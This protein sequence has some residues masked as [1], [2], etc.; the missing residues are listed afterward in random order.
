MDK[1]ACI[2]A[3]GVWG[4]KRSLLKSRDR[5]YTPAVTLVREIL[6]GC[7]VAYMRDDVTGWCEGMNEHG[8]GITNAALAVG[9][10]E[11]EGKLVKVT[12]KTTR[13]GKRIL[14]A[15]ACDNIDDAVESVCE[16]MNGLKG[17]T[18]L[19]T[20]D[21]V[22]CVEQ[23]REHEC[24]VKELN[25]DDLH[26]RTNHGHYHTDA[27]YTEGEDYVS[28]VIRREKALLTLRDLDTPYDLGPGLMKGRMEDRKDPNNMVRD[29]NNMSTTSQMVMNLSD[30]EVC[31]YVLP[32]KMDYEGL[33]DN[34]PEGYE[35]KI[36]LKVYGYRAG[37]KELVELS[38]KTGLR[39]KSVDP[40]KL[41]SRYLR[42][43]VPEKYK[44]IDFKPP[45]SVA[46]AAEKGL[47][48]RQK[49]SPSNRGGLTPS[50]AAEQGIG[51]G[52]QRAVNLKNRDNISPEVI[53]QMVGFFSRHEKNKGVSPEHKGEPWNDK[54]NVAWLIWGGDPGRAWAEK[55]KGQMEA[56]DE[57]A[58]KNAARHELE[59]LTPVN[60]YESPIEVIEAELVVLESLWSDVQA[61]LEDYS[62]SVSM[63]HVGRIAG[64]DLALHSQTELFAKCEHAMRHAERVI[65]M[66]RTQLQLSPGNADASSFLRDAQ[67]LYDRF[68]E[69]R[70]EAR[71]VLSAI[72]QKLIPTN[73]K[74]IVS[75]ALDAVRKGLDCPNSV[76]VKVRSRMSPVEINGGRVEA[77]TF[78]AF[79]TAYPLPEHDAA[80]VPEY[81]QFIFTQSTLGDTSVYLREIDRRNKNAPPKP[82]KVTNGAAA[83]K[84]ILDSLDGWPNLV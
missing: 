28:S 61:V 4:G 54:G 38:P 32:G 67:M 25:P 16:Y 41:A 30:R 44:H 60:E 81:Q 14:K 21:K 73:L 35:P 51:S 72:S 68:A 42:A 66:C 63:P 55:V 36:R 24:R 71:E 80:G 82:V 76:T 48:Y 27:G 52:V 23:T 10:D 70:A 64:A 7:E 46:D 59:D 8:L 40:V 31:F 69:G 9:I 20:P 12:G 17:H 62:S 2:I 3:A 49:A 33:E 18:F 29:T 58:Q 45:Q 5:N 6:D 39:R 78:D 84:K 26:V 15:L 74:Q 34:L 65:N 79:V 83:A 1:T 43:D 22:V 75:E 13:D 57:K 77:Q 11:A 50:E 19:A 56:A 37:G 53:K 47:E